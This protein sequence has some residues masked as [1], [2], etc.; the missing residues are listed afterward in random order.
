MTWWLVFLIGVATGALLSL[1]A[2][3]AGFIIGGAHF[4][5]NDTDS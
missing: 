5:D 4:K 3:V 1:I 2:G